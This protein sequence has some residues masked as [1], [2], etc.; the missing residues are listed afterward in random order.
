MTPAL[1]RFAVAGALLAPGAAAAAPPSTATVEVRASLI[2]AVSLVG[3]APLSFGTI[4]PSR[5]EPATVTVAPNGTVSSSAPVTAPAL[6]APSPGPFRVTGQA[7]AF[8]QVAL[9]TEGSITA[10]GASMRL[11]DFTY[12]LPAGAA[13]GLGRLD[14]SG[15]AVF[16]VGATL[17]VGADQP[18]GEYV[19]A[20][21]VTVRYQ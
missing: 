21:P 14:P 20:Y 1:R 6:Q 17:N 18:A 4:I 13:G 11:T 9:P 8:F 5:T 3:E 16:T 10:G 12:A 15:R 7:N 2:S 19:G